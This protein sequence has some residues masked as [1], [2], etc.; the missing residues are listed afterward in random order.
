[1]ISIQTFGDLIN[2]HPHL[3]CF[4]TDGCFMPDGWFYVLPEIDVKKL[5]SL[6]RHKVFRMLLKENKISREL[7]EKLLSWKNSGFNIYNHVKIQSH[8]CHGRESLAQYILRSPFSQQ[9]MTYR[10]DTQTV[11]YRSKMNPNL[12]RNFALFPVLDS[13][14]KITAHIPNKGGQSVRYYG[15]YS[16]VS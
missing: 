5:E 13:I 3:H 7:V 4:V 9:K 15:T 16:N 1:M 8:D 11:L 14:A 12:N 2:F 6:F 10:K